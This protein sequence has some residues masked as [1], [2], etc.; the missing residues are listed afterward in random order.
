[1]SSKILELGCKSSKN[2]LKSLFPGWFDEVVLHTEVEDETT[3]LVE[4]GRRLDLL[5]TEGSS[6]DT[7]VEDARVE[8]GL[9]ADTRFRV[10]GRCCCKAGTIA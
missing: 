5:A 4:D 10:L 9:M 3:D 1:M 6:V 7:L 2:T 8:L